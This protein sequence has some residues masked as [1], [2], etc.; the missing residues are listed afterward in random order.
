MFFFVISFL[1]D[2]PKSNNLKLA[3]KSFQYFLRRKFWWVNITTLYQSMLQ[4]WHEQILYSHWWTSYHLNCDNFL[5][6]DSKATLKF[7]IFELLAVKA[8][9]KSVF[10]RS[11]SCYGDLLCHENDNNVF[12]D[13]A[14]FLIPWLGYELSKTERAVTMTNANVSLRKVLK[15]VLIQL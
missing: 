1:K 3:Q 13:W 5:Y 11:Y 12:N 4:S 9:S 14:A 6:M 15:T 10:R 8:K 2:L 7:R